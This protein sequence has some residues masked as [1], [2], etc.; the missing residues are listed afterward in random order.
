MELCGR[1]IFE[2]ELA[3][4]LEDLL[5][6]A[7][8]VELVDLPV[9]RSGQRQATRPLLALCKLGELEL[10]HCR[11]TAH[12]SLLVFCKPS[13]VLVFPFVLLS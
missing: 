7:E 12:C 10:V 6:H 9:H 3:V 4:L 5:R 1:Q 11:D 2:L 13:T 8:L